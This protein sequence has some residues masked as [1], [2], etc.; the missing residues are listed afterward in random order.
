METSKK[1]S[2]KPRRKS[3]PSSPDTD[4]LTVAMAMYRFWFRICQLNGG[5]Q[6]DLLYLEK[7]HQENLRLLKMSHSVVKK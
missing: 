3:T 2:S 7:A 6:L 4:S 1:R 5:R